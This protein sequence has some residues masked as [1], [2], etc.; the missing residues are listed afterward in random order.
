M[1][2]IRPAPGDMQKQID[3][4][5]GRFGDFQRRVSAAG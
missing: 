4:G 5:R 1:I 3:L 2:A